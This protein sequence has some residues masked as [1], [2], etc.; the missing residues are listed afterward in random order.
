MPFMRLSYAYMI[1]GT[2]WRATGMRRPAG[3][4]TIFPKHCASGARL[5]PAAFSGKQFKM[6]F[7]IAGVL[8]VS[9]SAEFHVWLNCVDR[10]PNV[11][12][13]VVI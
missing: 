7:I 9:P 8:A 5:V 13:T 2:P 3:I 1:P 4:C 6:E 10:L 11:I 12:S